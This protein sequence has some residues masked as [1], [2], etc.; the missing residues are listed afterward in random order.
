MLVSFLVLLEKDLGHTVGPDFTL[1]PVAVASQ[2]TIKEIS[3]TNAFVSLEF[4]VLCR[5]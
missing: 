4:A 3:W 2:P 5:N 1:N